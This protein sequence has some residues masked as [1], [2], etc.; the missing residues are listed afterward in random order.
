MPQDIDLWDSYYN[1]IMSLA[2][3]QPDFFLDASNWGDDNNDLRDIGSGKIAIYAGRYRIPNKNKDGSG[4]HR[5]RITLP[6]GFNE[7]KSNGK[8]DVTD[9]I[10]I[11]T[12]E[13]RQGTGGDPVALCIQDVDGDGFTVTVIETSGDKTDRKTLNLDTINWLAIGIV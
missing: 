13:N 3:S 1:A 7:D 6:P 2:R 11:V 5:F 4:M 8:S 12:P 10:I 9:P